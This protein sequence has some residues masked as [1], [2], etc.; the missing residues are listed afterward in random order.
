MSPSSV[1]VQPW[2]NPCRSHNE[3]Q[4]LPNIRLLSKLYADHELM[5]QDSLTF[6]HSKNK[7]LSLLSS[8][9]TVM[10]N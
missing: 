9:T 8:K 3:S 7:N 5:T 10:Y 4:R 6:S 1:C 2:F